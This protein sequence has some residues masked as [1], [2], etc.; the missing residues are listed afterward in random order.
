M[1]FTVTGSLDEPDFSVNPLSLL[2]PGILRKIFSGRGKSPDEDF[3]E[4]LKREVD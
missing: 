4:S 1:T 2:A 3:I